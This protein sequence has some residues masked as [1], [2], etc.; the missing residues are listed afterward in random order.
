MALPVPTPQSL[1]QMIQN[2]LLK[3]MQAAQA[4]AQVKNALLQTQYAEPMRQAELQQKEA[5]AQMPFGG[6]QL[7]GVAG[8]VAGIE[9]IKQKYGEDSP[10]FQQAQ[11]GYQLRQDRERQTKDYQ[12]SLMESASKRFA[13][14]LAKTLMEQQEV[15]QGLMPGTTA[16]GGE[17]EPLSPEKQMKAMQT[18]AQKILKDTTDPDL[19]KRARFAINMDTTIS[20]LNA[21]DLTAYSGVKGQAALA[22]D[23]YLAQQGKAPEKLIRYEEAVA[24]A[25]TLSKQV[26]QFLADSITKTTHEFLNNLVNPTGWMVSPEV[27]LA[28]Y[29]QFVGTLARESQAILR[30]MG[31]ESI[32]DIAKTSNPQELTWN[33]EKGTWE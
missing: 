4:P 30:E 33:L 7:P 29:N 5:L 21:N 17:G 9:A 2:S 20:R 26:R 8:E 3:N 18:Y 24:T 11:Q 16:A 6:R 25:D 1:G 10:L 19:R 12:K 14:P 31:G 32:V 22:R 15:E 28:K 13:T 27:A 23:R